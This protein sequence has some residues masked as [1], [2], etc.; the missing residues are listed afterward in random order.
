MHMEKYNK[1]STEII[2][3]NLSHRLLE[4]DWL[5]GSYIVN[6]MQE[7]KDNTDL[8]GDEANIIHKSLWEDD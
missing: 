7:T 1:P 4:E 3:V 6:D 8:G 5:R 2:F